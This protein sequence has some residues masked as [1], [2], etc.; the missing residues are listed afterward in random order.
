MTVVFECIA[1]AKNT[2]AAEENSGFEEHMPGLDE[3]GEALTE[4][5]VCRIHVEQS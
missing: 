3:F 4:H 5:L 2:Y 1:T